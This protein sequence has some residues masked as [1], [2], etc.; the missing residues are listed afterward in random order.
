MLNDGFKSAPKWPVYQNAFQALE[1]YLKA[2]LLMKGATVDDLREKIGHR[3][4]DALVE[5]KA[6]GL[7]LKFDPKAEEAVMEVSELY[8]DTQLRYTAN[9]QWTLVPPF[10]VISLADQ[11]RRDARL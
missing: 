9:G 2:Y 10:L 5:A 3:L 11:V 1:L 8:T 4:K 6:K 7:T